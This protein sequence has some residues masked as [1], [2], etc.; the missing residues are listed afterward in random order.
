MQSAVQAQ[1][2]VHRSHLPVAG[3]GPEHPAETSCPSGGFDAAGG[4]V[5]VAAVAGRGRHRPRGRGCG[6]GPWD[7]AHVVTV[8]PAADTSGGPA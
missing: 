7:L 8:A 2:C 1:W 6:D 5:A 4:T 3:G